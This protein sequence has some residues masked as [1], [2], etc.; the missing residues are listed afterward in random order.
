MTTRSPNVLL[1]MTDQERY[2]TP[3]EDEAVAEFRRTQLPARTRL[4]A[5]GVQFHRHYA[6]ATACAPS[7]ATLFT[8]QYPSLH[9]VKSTDGLAK[10][11]TDVQMQ[12]LDPGTVPTLGHWFQAAGYRTYYK[13]KWHISHANISAPG[14]HDGIKASDAQGRVLQEMVELYA[15]TDRLEPFGFG[16]WVGREPHGADLADAGS[17]RDTIFADQVADLF[18]ELGRDDDPRPWLAVA[19]FVNPHD[20]IFAGPAWDMLGLARPDDT[21]PDIPEAPSQSDGFDDR[22]G[23]QEGW[24]QTWPEMAF[25][26]PNDNAYRRLYYWLHKQV[27][28]AI[29]AVLDAL[30]ASD[31]AEDTI[32]VFTSDHGDL[33]GAHGGMKQKWYNAYEEAIHVPMVIRGP[34]LPADAAGIDV[35]TSHIDLVP[36]LLGLIGADPA[37]L[38]EVVDEH[39]TEARPLPGRNLA[40]IVRAP[41]GRMPRTR[42]STS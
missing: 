29:G 42:R 18:G 37:D 8:G 30:D 7:R 25:D 28:A 10:Y 34:G 3:Y 14:S 35:P 15:K 31:L 19:S 12:W 1:I 22:P 40:A 39:H 20:I 13:G 36:T 2:P 11:A 5:E 33:L 4:L 41:G 27:D 32:V 24:V 23:C 21:V 9:G 38:L 6:G 16:G 26:I 17:V